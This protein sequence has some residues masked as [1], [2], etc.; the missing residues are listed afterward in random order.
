MGRGAD[1]ELG[2]KLAFDTGLDPREFA[3]SQQLMEAQE[4]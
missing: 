1:S 2:A 3:A 4:F